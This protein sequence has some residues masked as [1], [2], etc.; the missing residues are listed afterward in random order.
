MAPANIFLALLDSASIAH[1]VAKL[2]ALKANA[3][4]EDVRAEK[5]SAA[6]WRH[7]IPY[8]AQTAP[9]AETAP[10][11]EAETAPAP[12]AAAPAPVAAAAKEALISYISGQEEII[13]SQKASLA[14]QEEKLAALKAALASL[15]A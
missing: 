9:E 5:S 10:A 3:E 1:D 15:S 4:T 8:G 12:E 13:A 6:E 14:T 7:P 2:E 11:P